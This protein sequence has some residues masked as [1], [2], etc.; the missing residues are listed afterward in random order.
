M[1]EKQEEEKEEEG[2]SQVE[3]MKRNCNS[4]FR[5]NRGCLKFPKPGHDETRIF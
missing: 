3:H 5:S 1:E 4:D 2:K